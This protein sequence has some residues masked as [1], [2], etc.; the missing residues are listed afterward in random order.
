MKHLDQIDAAAKDEAEK[1]KLFESHVRDC[2]S[3]YP[4]Y[5]HQFSK[6]WLWG[7]WAREQE[8]SEQDI[9]ID[10]VA[11]KEN[12]ELCSIQCKFYDRKTVIGK[13]DINSF[14][15]ATGMSFNGEKFSECYLISTTDKIGKNASNAI[16]NFRIP[17]QL[18]D[19]YEISPDKM[20]AKMGELPEKYHT[21][22]P[23]KKKQL[24]SD[25]EQAVTDVLKGLQTADR[26]KLIM[27]CGTGKT[28]VSLKIAERLSKAKPKGQGLIL[29]LVPSLALLSQTLREWAAQ[30]DGLARIFAVCSDA[31]AGKDEEDVRINELGMTPTTDS[32][33]LAAQLRKPLE[34]EKSGMTVIFATYQSIEVVAAAQQKLQQGTQ[35][36]SQQDTQQKTQ[37]GTQQKTQQKNRAI[38]DLIICDE[39]HRTTGIEAET[40]KTSPF[41]LVHDKDYIKAAKRLYMT[42]TPRIYKESAKQR[43]K[44]RDVI[45]YSMDDEA[46]YGEELHRLNF[47]TAVGRGLLADYKVL[48]L[49]VSPAYYAG[50][51]TSLES[52]LTAKLIGC[53]NGLAK[54]IANL[55]EAGISEDEKPMKRAVAFCSTIESSEQMSEQ[56]TKI[57][58]AYHQETLPQEAQEGSRKEVLECEMRHVD[59]TQ[60]VLKRN[61][62]L[63]WLKD[64]PGDYR[65]RI[66]SNVRCLSEGVD[67]PALDAVIFLQPRKSQVDIVQSVGRVMRK[68]RG[69]KY[70]YIILPIPVPLDEDA[71]KALDR[72]DR[73]GVVWDVLQALRSH[74]DR[75]NLEINQLELNNEPSERIH[76]KMIDDQDEEASGKMRERI[77]AQQQ[78]LDIGV[79][80]DAILARIVLKCGDRRYWEKWAKEV[81]EIAQLSNKRIEAQ[82]KKMEAK[83]DETF[84]NFLASLRHNLNPAVS[85]ADAIDMLSQHIVTRPVFNALFEDYDFAERNPVSV[86]MQ[87][88]LDLL[89]E[90]N[91]QVETEKLEGFYRSVAERAKGIDNIAG[92]Q[93]VIN[94]LYEE[95]FRTAFPQM[96]DRLGIVYTPPEVV[97]FILHSANSLLQKEFGRSLSSENVNVLDPFTGTGT[98]ISRLLQSQLIK[99]EDLGR[100]Y[101]KELH[102]NEIVLLAYYIAAINIE[103]AFHYRRQQKESGYGY[104]SFEGMVLTDSFQLHEDKDTEDMVEETLP[105]NSDRADEQ[106]KKP[107]Q[108]ILG[109]PPYSAKQ[110]DVHDKSPNLSYPKLDEN[111]RSSYVADGSATNK[112][113]LYDSYIRAIRWASD[114]LGKEGII[115]F[116]TNGSYIDGNAADGIRKHLL[117]DFTSVYCFNLRGNAWVFGEKQKKEGGNIFGQSSR[118][119]IAITFLVRNPAV[120]T[121]KLYYRNIGD[122]LSRKEKLAKLSQLASATR[123]SWQ[124][125]KP[126]S[127][128]DW[129][130]QRDP[131]FARFIPL[132][133]KANKSRP[134]SMPAIFNQYSGGVATRRDGWAYNFS[135]SSLKKNMAGMIDFYNQQLQRYQLKKKENSSL[136]PNQVLSMDRTRIKWDRELQKY[137]VKGKKGKINFNHIRLAFYRPFVPKHLYFDRQFNSMV[138]LQPS[139][140]PQPGSINQAICVTGIS[141][142]VDFSA[143]MV[144]RLPDLNF[145]NVGQCF[146]RYV[147]SKEPEDLT[148]NDG[149]SR[150][151]NISSYALESFRSHYKDEQIDRDAIFY[152]VYGLLQHPSY[153]SKF[154]ADLYKMLPRIPFA[155]SLK[156]FWAFSEAGK[157]LGQL[158]TGY[159]ELTPYKLQI[160]ETGK[161]DKGGERGKRDK[162][163]ERDKYRVTKMRFAGKP[164][165][166][167]KSCIQ[168]NDYIFIEGIPL[169]AYD[170]K[171][172]G[173][174]AL[175]WLMNCYQVK[176]DKDNGI[177]QDPNQWSDNPR[178]IIELIG[179]IVQL[180]LTT[181]KEVAKLPELKFS[182][183]EKN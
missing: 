160:L 116:V 33:R 121:H 18:V 141:S 82:V 175:E 57:I 86:S 180:S 133:D 164:G 35:Q 169:A 173:K 68:S 58:E 147:Y 145:Y 111:I 112:V 137:L 120:S 46:T 43:A 74:D 40:K 76:I 65:C 128:H 140:F 93:K 126:N 60:N 26:G 96:A 143:L 92:K 132:G 157:R 50:L 179:K 130:N 47:S 32:E 150:Q 151:D 122:Y 54:R 129:I 34:K 162:R 12:G 100:K 134:G 171:V 181:L 95:F 182:E 11:R 64:E 62:K 72:N 155:S 6:V 67:V 139:F 102:A 16:A 78:S 127:Y 19:Y 36:K 44:E 152:Y 83:K 5:Q 66:L 106:K 38:F 73:Y 61:Q 77:E 156:D 163:D 148:D 138:Y 20:A 13:K 37:Q 9:G 53:W 59:G 123:M 22:K 113:N 49:G 21:P 69:K 146:P 98:F 2:L 81:G 154:S 101:T 105:D 172:S 31:K 55:E 166:P 142:P 110:K 144:A 85:Q 183:E 168:Y 103:Q 27:A 149:N 117:R 135:L 71:E 23:P 174:S 80:R 48:I 10:L 124:R 87:N 115:G 131:Q 104:S 153:K 91:V 99:D 178:Y 159:E 97:D 119:T 114:R 94:E 25:Q 30:A 15:T 1:G 177:K 158:H 125:I 170:Y 63:N 165:H 161:G 176:I 41:V 3:V 108:I 118:A 84:N 29:L 45:V 7:E 75:F 4:L 109:N 28:L 167:D 24:R 8:M 17:C 39:A 51:G 88:M 52:N 136:S 90:K 14:L 70:G 89:E 56:F 107:I 79:W 42:A